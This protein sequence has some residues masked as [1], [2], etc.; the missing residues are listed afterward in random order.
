VSFEQDVLMPFGAEV[1]ESMAFAF[2]L[3]SY[4]ESASMRR[5]FY[6]R[7]ADG[8]MPCDGAWA[9]ADVALFRALG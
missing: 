2:D 8:T 6:S 9:E 4:E 3:S 5:R 1:V 7:L